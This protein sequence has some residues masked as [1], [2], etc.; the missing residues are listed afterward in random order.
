MPYMDDLPSGAWVW[1]ESDG[2]F[3][4]YVLV[5]GFALDDGLAKPHR[6][7]RLPGFATFAEAMLECAYRTDPK[8]ILRAIE[9]LDVQPLDL[10][11]LDL[12]LR[13]SPIGQA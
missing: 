13:P 2:S 7:R 10:A 1:A 6:W 3:S 9:P 8:R 5:R 11:P 4:V 12:R